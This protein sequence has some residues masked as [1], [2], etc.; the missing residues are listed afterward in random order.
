MIVEL[1]KLYNLRHIFSIRI[2]LGDSYNLMSLRFLPG[3]STA[4]ST[5]KWSQLSWVSK[6]YY[7]YSKHNAHVDVETLY[8]YP[9]TINMM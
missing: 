8:Q 9:S 2:L 6:Q 1:W 5:G 4:K 7:D 3:D